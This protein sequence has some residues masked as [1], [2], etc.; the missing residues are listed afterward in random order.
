MTEPSSA[1]R[2]DRRKQ[3][4]STDRPGDG[5]TQLGESFAVGPRLLLAVMPPSEG[6]TGVNPHR[7]L[8]YLLR[9]LKR[10]SSLS[11]ALLPLVTPDDRFATLSGGSV[12]DPEML[13]WYRGLCM[14]RGSTY[15]S[16]CNEAA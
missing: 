2:F 3:P 12:D 14:G 16:T 10:G 5:Q 13:R 15:P 6:W 1:R 7:V 9:T 8:P 4:G 11:V